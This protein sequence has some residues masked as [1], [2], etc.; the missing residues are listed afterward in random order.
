MDDT[1]HT[2]PP[3]NAH[4]PFGR[5]VREHWAIEEDC[6]FLN[7]G[8]FGATPLLVLAAQDVWRA[9]MERQL[10]RFFVREL[11][12]ALRAAADA[13]GAFI[14]AAGQ[15]LVFV[16][17]ATSGANAV[18]RSI[19][20]EPGDEILVTNH[21]YG[22]ICKAAEFAA[23]RAGA[24]VVEA[25][26]P[27]PIDSEEAVAQAVERA[28]T[29][30]T[31]LAII[32][33]VTSPS[34]LVFPVHEVVQLCHKHDVKI[35][36]D[37]AHAPGMLPL[38]VES[39]GADWYT[40]NCHKWLFAA[41]GCG[42][43]WTRRDLQTE[44]HSNVIS[45]GLDEGYCKE[46]DWPGTADPSPWLSVTA[47]IEFHEVLG[48]ARIRQRNQEVAARMGEMLADAW[49]T[50]LPAPRQMLGSM[51][52]VE[53]PGQI[54]PSRETADKLHDRLID[55]HRV[56]AP[57]MDFA[58]RLWVR[59]CAQVFNDEADFEALRDAMLKIVEDN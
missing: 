46:F 14:G 58:G 3:L 4:T 23:R 19:R 15:D 48:S 47:A 17:N 21:G 54:A 25:S 7:N 52:T 40:G 30:R 11:P 44:T 45:W 12:D 42:F 20:W 38:D 10:V 51:V 55:E 32:D 41:K 49:G 13:L 57:I 6:V 18:L 33:H 37:G 27:F 8:S 24:R 28:I 56:E 16:P 53:L 34:A 2:A 31:R 1:G 39:I 9:R 29:P 35:L 26:V 59:P 50:C 36:I 5:S 43:L 22:A